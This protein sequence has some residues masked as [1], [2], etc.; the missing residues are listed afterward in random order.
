MDN[1]QRKKSRFAK[2]TRCGEDRVFSY[3]FHQLK[4]MFGC[5]GS[6]SMRD[7]HESP[8]ESKDCRPRPCVSRSIT[9]H[10]IAVDREMHFCVK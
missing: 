4:M 6:T 5:M 3:G 9:N 8:H 10:S 2:W 1:F 7:R